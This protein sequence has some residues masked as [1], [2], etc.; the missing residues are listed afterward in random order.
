MNWVKVPFYVYL[1][2]R[3]YYIL[4]SGGL[5]PADIFLIITLPLL[6]IFRPKECVLTN[7]ENK[8]LKLF[9]LFIFYTVIVNL[10]YMIIYPAEDF[11]DTILY[12]M[13]N[14]S[15]IIVFTF[16][17]NDISFLKNFYNIQ[18]INLIIQLLILIS[19]RGR[20]MDGVRYIGTF[21]DP[22]QFSFYVFLAMIYIYV[23]EDLLLIKKRR[24]I[25]YLIGT[26]LIISSAS[27]GMILGLI[28][29]FL[30]IFISEFRISKE[31]FKSFSKLALLVLV[32]G[33][34]VYSTN[35]GAV[36]GKV[37]Y[38]MSRI[39]EKMDSAHNES[40]I[41]LMEDR[42]YDKIYK[43]VKYLFLGS[44]EGVFSMSRLEGYHKQEIHGTFP[45][46]LLYYGIP[47]LFLILLWLYKSLS[48]IPI[49]QQLVFMALFLES[50]TLAHQRQFL[51]WGV[52]IL[53]SKVKNR[54]KINEK[55]II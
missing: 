36:S 34:G 31:Q 28:I 54:R 5:Q 11:Y 13:F 52:I 17:I 30:S 32:V 27:T 21:N 41:G 3:P 47:G 20:D 29:F 14:L 12:Y 46:F 49:N 19:N 6:F 44:G 51:F 35:K 7:F 33:V 24:W 55:R 8:N 4:E 40:E 2:L 45:S 1:F 37:S 43:N 39:E 42:G 15:G 16:L 25:I 22:N 23:L 38:L 10:S 53:M 50:C 18:S 48:E 9:I 26:Y